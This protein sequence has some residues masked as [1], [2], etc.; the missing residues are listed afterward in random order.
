VD[1][2]G[3][4]EIAIGSA[5]G[6]ESYLLD[7]GLT[8][9]GTV[10]PSTSGV[11]TYNDPDLLLLSDL[12]DDGFA[13]G[14]LGTG[15]GTTITSAYLAY[16]SVSGLQVS[17]TDTIS[18]YINSQPYTSNFDS[19]FTSDDVDGDGEDDLVALNSYEISLYTGGSAWDTTADFT[20][21]TKINYLYAHLK[22]IGDLDED[23]YE[24][25]AIADVNK[26]YTDPY[27][28]VINKDA[29][30]VYL[31]AGGLDS[32]GNAALL[33]ASGSPATSTND[34]VWTVEG[35][36]PSGRI[37]GTMA[38]AGDVDGDGSP[39]MALSGGH[40]YS[41]SSSSTLW[42]GPLSYNGASYFSSDADATFSITGVAAPAGDMD[43]D[44]YDDI[45]F[46]GPSGGKTTYLFHGTPN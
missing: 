28:G 6:T 32:S 46:G 36:D 29:G 20:M 39:D 5:S 9:L 8:G 3:Y 37:G 45:W 35:V 25:V 22:L 16:G 41:S 26:T 40:V 23:G 10:T 13:D 2:D 38:P 12:N 30:I 34:A 1:G 42:Y 31:F 14:L 7:E 15:T 21:T 33:N 43:A 17:A 19:A 44:G 24:D 11:T 18:T 4:D 27:T